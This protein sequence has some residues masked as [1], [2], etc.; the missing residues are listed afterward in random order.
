MSCKTTFRLS[1]RIPLKV[2][3]YSIP[4]AFVLLPKSI[5]PKI[6]DLEKLSVSCICCFLFQF[7]GHKRRYDTIFNTCDEKNRFFNLVYSVDT[8]PLNRTAM[9]NQTTQVA[10]DPLLAIEF[11]RILSRSKPTFKNYFVEHP[12]VIHSQINS[13]CAAK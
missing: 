3:L 6:F 12:S 10:R 8:P 7:N 9:M 2:L 11:D 5:V 1:S 13:S 4:V